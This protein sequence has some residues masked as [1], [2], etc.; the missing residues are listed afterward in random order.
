MSSAWAF[1]QCQDLLLRFDILHRYGDYFAIIDIQLSM[2][3]EGWG[4]QTHP[5]QHNPL[6]LSPRNLIAAKIRFHVIPNRIALLFCP[7]IDSIH[8]QQSEKVARKSRVRGAL[9]SNMFTNI[10]TLMSTFDCA[11]LTKSL[12]SFVLYD[13][14]NQQKGRLA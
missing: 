1:D 10:R 7:G 9:S 3:G 12:S 8:L 13:P 14:S 5:Q 6:L 4:G 2:E 11:S